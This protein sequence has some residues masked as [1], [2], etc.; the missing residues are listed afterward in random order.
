MEKIRL[1]DGTEREVL[2]AEELQILQE[3]A[4]KVEDEK[5]AR[6]AAEAKVKELEEAANPNWP[7]IRKQLDAK[8]T[9]E[10]QLKA[11]GKTF[12]AS[13]KIIDL[14]IAPP[15]MDD[16]ART[17][18]EAARKELLNAHKEQ[19]MLRYSAEERKAIEFYFDKFS[20]G[21]K[22]DIAKIDRFI[23]DAEALVKPKHPIDNRFS[24]S[25]QAPRVADGGQLS[26]DALEFARIFGNTPNDLQNADN[27][28]IKLN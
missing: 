3:E 11:Q 10:E 28:V 1:E 12:D 23:T 2:T 4:K 6:E 25:G 15:S 19:Q 20:T 21:E 18:S 9:M 14:S 5:K 16:V 24:V 26:A 7:D 22:L 13:G 8:K 17:A 27:P